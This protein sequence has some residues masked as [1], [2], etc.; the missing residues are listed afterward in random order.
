MPA[1]HALS[2]EDAAGL[3]RLEIT[4][5]ADVHRWRRIVEACRI[6]ALDIKLIRARLDQPN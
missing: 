3:P 6:T 2:A 5:V 1:P 4:G